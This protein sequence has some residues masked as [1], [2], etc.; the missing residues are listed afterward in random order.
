MYRYNFLLDDS[1]TTLAMNM[2][3]A[4]KKRKKQGYGYGFMKMFMF[5]WRVSLLDLM[6]I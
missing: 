3:Y 2:I 6:N 4:G 5:K 1:T